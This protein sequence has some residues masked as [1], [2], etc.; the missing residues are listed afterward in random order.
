MFDQFTTRA[1]EVIQLARMEA[2]D[3]K[4]E[5]IGTEH[6]LLGIIGRKTGIAAEALEEFGI[7]VDEARAAVRA[8]N[9]PG[10]YMVPVGKVTYTSQSKRAIAGAVE[11]AGDLGGTWVEPEHLFLGLLHAPT[12]RATQILSELGINLNEFSRRILANLPREPSEWRTGS[13]HWHFESWLAAK[14]RLFFADV[15]RWLR[16]RIAFGGMVGAIAGGMVF[17]THGAAAGSAYGC[18]VGV[19]GWLLPGML[20]GSLVGAVLG[21]SYSGCDAVLLAGSALGTMVAARIMQRMSDLR[22]R[23]AKLAHRPLAEKA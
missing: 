4:C 22:P 5:L 10:P 19:F 1:T 14:E 13:R 7:N 6:I 11:A 3:C 17:G 18:I 9:P 15:S 20:L 23:H 16:L 21:A 12:S 2:Q 8:M